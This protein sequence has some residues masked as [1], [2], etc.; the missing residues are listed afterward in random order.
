MTFRSVSGGQ[1]VI[2]SLCSLFLLSA[3]QTSGGDGVLGS[4][5]PKRSE[6]D[7]QIASVA[8]GT[9]P[10]ART[11]LRNTKN[12]LTD[13]CPA[14]RIRAGTE[15]YQ[16]FPKGADKENSDNVRY[17][18]TITKVARECNYVGQNLQIKVGARGRT[19]TGP[20]GGPGTVTTPIRVAVTRG[21]EVIYSKL[22]KPV[23]TIEGGTSFA[24]FAFVDDQIVIPAPSSRNIRLF[25]GFDEGPYKT[26]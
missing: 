16:D 18:S 15:I 5:L 17:Q 25:V 8:P 7:Q 26:P 19:I 3:C 4:V 2:L 12:E 14:V 24:Q 11:R 20:K 9:N 23:Q 10:N 21:T 1:S 22:H 6:P 13:Y